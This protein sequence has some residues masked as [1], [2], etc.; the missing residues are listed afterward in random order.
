MAGAVQT[1]TA[2]R[3]AAQRTA[4]TEAP[5]VKWL[6]VTFVVIFFAAFLLLPLAIIFVEAFSKGLHGYLTAFKDTA[7]FSAIKLTLLTVAVAVPL[8]TVFGLAAAWAI[9]R[10]DFR[11]KLRHPVDERLASKIAALWMRHCV[12]DEMLAAA[13]A[14]FQMQFGRFRRI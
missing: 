7:T 11:K 13:K 2:E 12:G 4:T 1:L 8:N 5:W 9:A 14:N 3:F 10:F 6:L